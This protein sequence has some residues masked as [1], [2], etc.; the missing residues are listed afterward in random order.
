MFGAELIRNDRVVERAT[1]AIDDF[2]DALAS[3]KHLASRL[4]NPPQLIRMI[5]REGTGL[6]YYPVAEDEQLER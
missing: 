6:G 4:A 1:I 2:Q 5:D 3:A